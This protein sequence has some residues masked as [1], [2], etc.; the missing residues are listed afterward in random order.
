MRDRI[1]A[2]LVTAIVHNK[3]T[4]VAGLVSVLGLAAARLGLQVSPDTLVCVAGLII[5][6]VTAAAGDS[7]RRSPAR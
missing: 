5:L 2:A 3:K 4:T 7:H 1:I 6:V